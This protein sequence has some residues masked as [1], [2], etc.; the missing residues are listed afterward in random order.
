[1]LR[2]R[3]LLIG[4]LPI[5]VDQSEARHIVINQSET[6]HVAAV[7][8]GGG[9]R[10]FPHDVNSSGA[11]WCDAHAEGGVERYLTPGDPNVTTLGKIAFKHLMSSS[12]IP[13]TL[14]FRH[15]MVI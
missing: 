14:N 7:N 10:W 5:V 6:R 12:Y 13:I 4:A 9:A 2:R 3:Q 11:Y 8:H 15:I 1:M